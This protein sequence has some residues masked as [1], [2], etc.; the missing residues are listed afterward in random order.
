MFPKIKY[1]YLLLLAA[2]AW[3]IFFSFVLQLKPGFS[4]VGDDGSYLFAARELYLHG[5]LNDARPLLIAAIDGFPLLLGLGDA[6]VIGWSN[7]INLVCWLLASWLV[8][9]ITAQ[10]FTRKIAFMAGLAFVFCIGNLANAFNMLAEPVFISMLLLAVYLIG[11][12]ERTKRGKYLILAL[13]VLVLAILVKP[14]AIGITA[15]AVFFYL[16]A[17][18]RMAYGK[19]VFVLVFS[20]S[21]LVFQLVGIKK[22]Y[23]DYTVSYIS[24]ITYYNYLGAKAD[25]LSKGIPFE[26]GENERAN[27]FSRFSSHQQK[28]IASAD[29]SRQV[30]HNTVNL[31]KAYLF[32][33]F[34]NSSKASYVVSE[35][36][37][38]SNTAYFDFFYFVLKATSK[39]QTI[40]F[41]V[42]GVVLSFLTLF[43]KKTNCFYKINA[44]ILLYIFFISA[45]SCMQCDRFHII[46]FPLA[47]VLATGFIKAKGQTI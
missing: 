19:S 26:P 31:A 29:F 23:G 47:I 43:G 18:R 9:S 34:S 17:L 27:Y 24:S 35:T 41:T 25:C 38:N 13:S 22:Q 40:V 15:I 12:F 39:M 32:C 20:I 4:A 36:K 21:L 2:V 5:R 33:I 37:N 42:L 28:K 46:F 45:L 16:K 10:R 30:R 1:D 3:G 6:A 11:E 7:T 44:L 8:F 14:L